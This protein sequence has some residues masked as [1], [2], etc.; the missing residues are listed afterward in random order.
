MVGKLCCQ[1]RVHRDL[2]TSPWNLDA[3]SAAFDEEHA[4]LVTGDCQVDL[5]PFS[6]SEAC[7]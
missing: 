3:S 1:Q 6:F 4:D 2:G 7:P 5:V